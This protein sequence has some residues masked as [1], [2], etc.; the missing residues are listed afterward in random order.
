MVYDCIVIGMGISGVSAAIYLKNSGLNICMFDKDSPGGLLNRINIVTNYPGIVKTTG[1]DLALE[2]YKSIEENKISYKMEEVLSITDDD[3]LKVI[4]TNNGIFKSKYV[5][6]AT[7]RKNKKLNLENEEKLIGKGLS[8]CA[9]CDGHLYKDEDIAVVGGGNSALEEALY[10]ANIVKKVYLIHRR[11]TFRADDYLVKEVLDKENIEILY[12]SEVTNLIE[13]NNL[14]KEIVI[15]N[16]KHLVVKAMFT[17]IGFEPNHNF[18]DNIEDVDGYIKV[19]E[20]YE[21]SIKNI[22]AVGD[23]IKKEV[24]QLI[25]AASDGVIASINIINDLKKK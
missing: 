17:Y 6:I 24:Y 23:A 4:K 1:P 11:D 15:N 16:D 8:N 25:T 13:E 22:Y 21:T 3:N 2:L 19:N 12:N 18:I 20:K 5:I 7:G 14:L 9:L 10:L